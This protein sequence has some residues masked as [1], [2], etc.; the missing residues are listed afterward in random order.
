MY[1]V[2]AAALVEVYRTAQFKDD[3]FLILRK[4]SRATYSTACARCVF[5]RSRFYNELPKLAG[6]NDIFGPQRG[7][8]WHISWQSGKSRGRGAGAGFRLLAE[9]SLMM[10]IY[11]HSE[12]RARD[13]ERA[14][15]GGT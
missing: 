14:R 12:N 3:P 1:Y 9:K 6:N 8:L 10:R 4:A 13:F 15:G 7:I 2:G 5:L 11:P